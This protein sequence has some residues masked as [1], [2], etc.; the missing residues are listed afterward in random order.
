VWREVREAGL[1]RRRLMYAVFAVVPALLIGTTVI[2]LAGGGDDAGERQAGGNTS[3]PRLTTTT[4]TTTTTTA[5]PPG[6][7][8]F[9][10]GIYGS[11][12]QATEQAAVWR[13]SRP[14]DSALMLRMGAAPIATWFGDWTPDVRAAAANLVVTAATAGGRPVL[15][16]YNMPRRDCEGYSGGGAADEN[17]YRAWIREFAAGIGDR[18]AA[19]ILEPDVLA[20][21]CGNAEATYRMLGDAIEVL[22]AGADTDVYLDAGHPKWLD[23]ATS[24]KR[25]K[26]AGV[27]KARGFA[28]NV[29]NFVT[30][31]ENERYG[32]EIVRTLGIETYYVID[33]S[34]NGNGEGSGWCNPPG[35]ALGATPTADTA[36]EHADAYLWV[37]IPGESDGPCDGAP[38]AGTWMPEYALGLARE[39]A[40]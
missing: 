34:R 35:R 33:T 1:D 40:R 26:A 27:A 5:R 25:L 31:A 21:L 18:P 10:R 15:V 9:V 39:S 8:A 14:A 11:H 12:P 6:E 19:V 4:S 24:A 7:S 23:V 36:G 37:K 17:A 38:P 29:S 20:M 16:A 32:E 30:T 13:D 3:A 2:V 28:L 22:E